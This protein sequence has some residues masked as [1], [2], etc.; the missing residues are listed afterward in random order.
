MKKKE[1]LFVLF[2]NNHIEI[3]RF[4]FFWKKTPKKLFPYYLDIQR[5]I[6]RGISF[7]C[8]QNKL[9]YFFLFILIWLSRELVFSRIFLLLFGYMDFSL[10]MFF[11]ENKTVFSC[12]LNILILRSR[13]I[14]LFF[15][16]VQKKT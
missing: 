13:G 15:L 5:W 7:F 10:K 2:G 11:G 4:F 3:S 14:S 1:T 16:C 6:F 8:V 12:F 9:F